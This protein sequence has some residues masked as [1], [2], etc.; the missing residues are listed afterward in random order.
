MVNL[1]ALRK[2]TGDTVMAVSKNMHN[3]KRGNASVPNQ[4]ALLLSELPDNEEGQKYRWECFILPT[5]EEVRPKSFRHFIT[6]YTPQGLGA[7]V[8]QVELWIKESL[9]DLMPIFRDSLA[10]TLAEHGEIGNGR[11]RVS[12]TKST[13]PDATYT[14]ARLKRDNPALAAK[15]INGELSPHAAAVQAGIRKP[16]KSFPVGDTK[17]FAAKMKREFSEAELQ[18]IIKLLWA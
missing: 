3:T 6:G 14:T 15:V 12:N 10:G 1:P 17:K 11:S 13:I 9:P 18:Q 8:E 4:L 16:Y 2:T 7:S 5:G